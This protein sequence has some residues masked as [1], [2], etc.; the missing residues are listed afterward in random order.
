MPSYCKSPDAVILVG[1][2][3][4]R[5]RRVVG[6]RPK[7]MAVVAGRP[8]VEWL[9]L[10]L[11]AQGVR[12]V[13]FCTGYMS[14]VVEAHFRDGRQWDMEVEYS[15]D[16]S[17]LGTAGAVRHALSQVRS[18]RFLVMNGDSFCR[19]DINRL[20]EVHTMHSARATLWLVEV[21]DCS[22]YG[23]VVVGTDG[24]VQAFREKRE[25]KIA[26]LISAG[27]YLMEREAA[28][29]I[30][31]GRAVS[32]ETEFFPRLIGHGLYGVVGDGPFLDI[33]TPE[34]YG[35]A[36]RLLDWRNMLR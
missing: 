15:C 11:R 12:R 35:E 16:P 2:K 26:G 19:V 34:A 4:A 30:P 24:A 3:G 1:G 20:V 7:P 27:V 36:E 22:R 33:G 29:T 6:D 23:S 28:D 32:L 21:N 25:Q 10:S 5:L 17:P 13:V 14:E 9:L 18:D 31:E 8:F